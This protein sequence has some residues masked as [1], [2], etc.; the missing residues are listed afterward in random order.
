MAFSGTTTGS[1]TKRQTK[2]EQK[3][4]ENLAA[5]FAAQ[6]RD[7][8]WRR[9][10]DPYAI[11][12]SEFMLQQTTV[13]AVTGYFARWMDR[14]PTVESLAAAA[15]KDVLAL[16]QGLGYYSRARNLQRAAQAVVERHGGRVPGSVEALR[17]LPGVGEYTAG[18][19]AAFAFDRPVPVIDANI[20]RVLARLKNWTAP[21]D[22]AAGRAFLREAAGV[23]LPGS[24]GRLHT[25]ALME[26]GALVCTARAPRCDRC[27]V[28]A[29]CR[30]ERPETLPVKRARP[31]IEAVAETRAFVFAQDRL[32]LE[33]SGGPR[34]RGLWILPEART[35]RRPVHVETYPIT[36][37][38][39]AMAVV[40]ES[41][42]RPGLEGFPLDALPPMPSP[43]R[44]AVAA[45]RTKRHS[46]I[47]AR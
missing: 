28:R 7:L 35:A 12:V 40:A 19:V 38:R 36:R 14:F 20:A 4:R 10:A 23:L 18:A 43:H 9:T 39:V 24:G 11:L 26:L 17:A 6:G 3:I 21:I 1:K 30:A 22:D 2:T 42:P 5:W 27:P 34:W 8:P 45:V 32:W 15:E 31:E 44:R 33:P 46:D 13:A 37:Y 16:W 41:L 25:S 47:H 29:L